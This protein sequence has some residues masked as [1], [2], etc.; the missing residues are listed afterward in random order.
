MTRKLTAFLLL[1]AG[2]GST[3]GAADRGECPQTREFGNHGCAR[4]LAVFEAPPQLPASY[5]Y[6][7]RAVPARGPSRD[8]LAAA[9]TPAPGEVPLN[10]TLWTRLPG[11]VDTL[12]VWVVA[13]LLEDP[14]PASSAPPTTF[15]AD[16]VLR[17]VRFAPIGE[18]PKTDTVRLTLRRP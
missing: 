6:H 16:S 17:V 10:I 3:T 9:V 12:S 14:G 13:Q 18:V 11:S 15:A 7:V 4:V 5:R 1:A 2:C 8:P